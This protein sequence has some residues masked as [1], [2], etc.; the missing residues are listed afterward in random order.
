MTASHQSRPSLATPPLMHDPEGQPRPEPFVEE[1][2][3]Q[4]G[5]HFQP[6]DRQRGGHIAGEEPGQRNRVERGDGAEA[7]RFGHGQ[8]IGFAAAT[9]H[10]LGA[11]VEPD[12][13]AFVEII[14][15]DLGH[16]FGDRNI[17]GDLQRLAFRLFE[18]EI[19]TD[20]ADHQIGEQQR[21]ERADRAPRDCL[22]H[23]APG[24]GFRMNGR[25]RCGG[26]RRHFRSENRN[27][28]IIR[29]QQPVL[30]SGGIVEQFYIG[31][32]IAGLLV[33]TGAMVR[34]GEH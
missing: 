21:V 26:Q 1:I 22:G 12:P 11:P 24:P 14:E 3:G 10:R 25:I 30:Q 6:A 18:P 15:Q 16:D 28:G 23:R 29:H 20:I 34:G 7:D 9:A 17:A 5:Y 33:R 32:G 4:L 2:E 31:W 8:A 19:R 27:L 13:E